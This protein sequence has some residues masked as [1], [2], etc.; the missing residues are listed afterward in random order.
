MNSLSRGGCS[1][2]ES[3]DS[4][5]ILVASTPCDMTSS[6]NGHCWWNRPSSL[7]SVALALKTVRN[8]RCNFRQFTVPQ[9][10]ECSDFLGPNIPE[11]VS[12]LTQV[13][14]SATGDKLVG[15]G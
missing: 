10:L 15:D 14:H 12:L 9:V 6:E 2:S 4:S 7:G 8:F 1:R 3:S 11:P 5:P 13:F